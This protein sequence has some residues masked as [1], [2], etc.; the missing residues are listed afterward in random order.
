[1]NA[2]MYLIGALAV[3]AVLFFVLRRPVREYVRM[4]GDRVVTCP[5]NEQIVAVQVDAG[6]AART[7][8]AG[9]E[10][11]RLESCTRW[12]E[13][14]GCGQECLRQIEDQ[15]EDCLVKTQVTRWY[16]GKACAL[17]GRALGQL[18]WAE[19]KPALMNPDGVTVMWSDVKPETIYEVFDS[20]A[21]ICWDCHIAETFRRTRPDLVIDN[22]HASG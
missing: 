13:K 16:A 6:Y 8:V 10:R 9:R 19:H 15:P 2:A 11:L 22:P 14:A 18:E 1:M 21:P 20:H 5:E 7:A 17:C 4:R 12:P 3:V